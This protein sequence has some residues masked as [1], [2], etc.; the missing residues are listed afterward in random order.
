MDVL[1]NQWW[2]SLH[3][4]YIYQIITLHTLNIL[5]LCQ[6]YLNETEKVNMGKKKKS[7]NVGIV[8]A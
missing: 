6:L 3:D 8:S 7:E 1:L 2:E 5:Q 4:I